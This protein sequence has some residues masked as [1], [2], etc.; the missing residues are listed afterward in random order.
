MDKFTLFFLFIQLYPIFGLKRVAIVAGGKEANIDDF[1][2]S[3][4]I[5]IIFKTHIREVSRLMA[6]IIS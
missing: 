6:M 3:V 5:Q 4:Y 1:P 2:W